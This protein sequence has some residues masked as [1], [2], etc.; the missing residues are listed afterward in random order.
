MTGNFSNTTECYDIIREYQAAG[1]TSCY[2]IQ[3]SADC[4]VDGYLPY[5]N[6]YYCRLGDSLLP[7][8]ISL[9]ILWVFMLFITAGLAADNFLCPS[10]HAIAK[11]LHLSE[12]LAG[13]TFLA[14]GNGAPDIM[15]SIIALHSI[16]G[17]PGLAIGE[18]LGGGIFV[19]TI[20]AAAVAI[21]SPFH[22]MRRPFL[23]D[24]AF[25]MAATIWIL[26]ILVRGEIYFWEAICFLALYGVYVLVAVLGRII[27]Q[28]MLKKNAKAVLTVNV[29]SPEHPDD[30]QAEVVANAREEPEDSV[31]ERRLFFH[32]SHSE[33]AVTHLTWYSDLMRG[34]LPKEVFRFRSL[35][36][37]KKLLCIICLPF[38]VMLNLTVPVV[39]EEKDDPKRGW[40]KV[41]RVINCV[42]LPMLVVV[43]V[44]GYARQLSGIFPAWALALSIALLIAVFVFFTTHVN[45]APWYHEFFAYLGFLGAC[46]WIYA[47]ANEIV[48]SLQTLGIALNI[49]TTIFGLTVLAWGNSIPDFIS[50]TSMARRGT[51]RVGISAA[52]AGPMMNLLLGV[53]ISFLFATR[54]T[55]PFPVDTTSVSLLS[56]GTLLFSLAFSLIFI[57]VSKFQ[58]GKLY[59]GLLI[60]LYVVFLALA[61]PTG[62]GI[63]M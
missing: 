32:R 8:S 6:L 50:N 28:S 31:E 15:S 25:Y 24:I 33:L 17:D 58:V 30:E 14:F 46:V 35:S 22:V 26:V 34:V 27:N 62:L 7:L 45:E 21:L 47:T 4:K 55:N 10:L 39:L 43:L 59:G 16:H 1:F 51:P 2:A 53:G 18:L 20:V 3:N 11:N 48:A 36:P 38:E 40:C 56:T 60:M 13:V 37:W 49:T 5:L 54:T 63:L 44:P 57:V 52:F 12:N 23:R 41:L 19:T 9:T 61:I 29:P 42:T